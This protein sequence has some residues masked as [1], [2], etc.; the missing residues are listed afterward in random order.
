MATMLMSTQGSDGD[1]LPFIRLGGELRRAGHD[2]T[3]FTHAPFAEHAARA[4]LE[5]VPVDTV[6]AY[7][8]HLADTM[9]LMGNSDFSW[10]EFNRRHGLYE[11]MADEI[12]GACERYRPGETV[13]IGRNSTCFSMRFAGELLGAPTVWV[14]FAPAQVLMAGLVAYRTR[15]QIAPTLDAMRREF[16]LGPVADWRRWFRQADLEIGLW[17]EWFDRA[18]MR[19]PDYVVRT[20]FVL[21]DEDPVE[22]LPPAVE[23]LLAERPVLLTT[24]TS[25]LQDPDFYRAA[26]EG[27]AAAGRPVLLV[28]RHADLMP[29]PLPEGVSWFPRLPFRDVAPSVSVFVHHGG[30]GTL[31]RALAAGVPQVLLVDTFDRPDNAQ[32]LERLGL[33]TWLPNDRWTR[34]EIAAAVSDALNDTDYRKRWQETVGHLDPA[35]GLAAAR[36]HIERLLIPAGV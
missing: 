1:V 24:G 20:G 34:E 15:N 9:A 18:G 17:P 6:S 8:Q 22:E 36:A 35:A 26:I 30:I 32:R 19:T 21:P 11:Q 7:K 33:A 16:G 3:L 13:L 27:C 29:D 25:R 12:R 31:T 10:D 2:V 23:E 28:T 5:F 14:S 4:G